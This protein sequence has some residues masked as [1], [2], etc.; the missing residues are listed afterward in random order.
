MYVN[1]GPK[2]LLMQISLNKDPENQTALVVSENILQENAVSIVSCRSMALGKS[3]C[4]E[5]N[6][7]SIGGRRHLGQSQSTEPC[8]SPRGEGDFKRGFRRGADV[9]H[10]LEGYSLTRK[11]L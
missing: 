3:A 5:G 9:F 2:K 10:G 4:A 1:E 6:T 7:K 8:S 11:S